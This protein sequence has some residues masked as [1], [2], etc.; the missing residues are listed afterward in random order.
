MNKIITSLFLTLFVTVAYS[1]TITV[2]KQKEKVK[3]ENIDAYALTL[4]GKKEDISSAWNKYLKEVGKLKLFAS[5]ITVSDPIMNGTTYTGKS[6]YADIKKN[7]ESSSTVWAGI[8]AAEWNES[9]VDDVNRGL[10]KL[11]YQFGV[12]YHRQKVQQQID[13]TEQALE[14]V[15]KQQQR[16]VNQNKDLTLKLTNNE[17][18]KIQLEKSLENNKLENASLKIKLENNKKAQDSLAHAGVQ[19]KKIM[20]THKEKQRKIN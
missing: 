8:N 15:Q 18:Q 14:A 3:G 19:I 1:Q 9:Q 17:Q 10:E 6:F 2:N 16:T 4:E 5:P 20:E 12:T 11:V 13:E 7:N